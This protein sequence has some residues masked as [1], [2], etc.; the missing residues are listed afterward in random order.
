MD[1][2]PCEEFHTSYLPPIFQLILQPVKHIQRIYRRQRRYIDFFKLPDNIFVFYR[3][4]QR[5]LLQID[6]VVFN[7]LL[8]L[9]L[10]ID[11]DILYFFRNIVIA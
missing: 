7:G 4:E 11:L 3:V 10:N 1:I 6:F 8:F 2:L 9:I 5:Y